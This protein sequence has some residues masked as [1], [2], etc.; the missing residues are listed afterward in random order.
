MKKLVIGVSVAL[1]L[2]FI[3]VF[4]KR[5]G[6]AQAR[7]ADKK[8]DESV[9]AVSTIV[10]TKRDLPEMV[11]ITGNVRAFNEAA[12]FPK[13]PGRVTKVNVEVG[14]IVKAGDV[15]AA[16]EGNDFA[17]RVKQ[18]EAQLMA[19]RA[20]L[21]NAQVQQKTATNGWNR[22]QALHGK[23]SMSQSDFEQS[24]AGFELS[25]VGVKAAEAQVALAEAAVGL[26]NQAYADTR[27]TSPI[28]G[29]VSKKNVEVGTQ[30]G[31][32]QPAFVVQDQSALKMQGSVSASEVALLKKGQPVKVRV[33]EL[34]GRELQGEVSSV[35]PS[36]DDVT[37]RATIEVAL[38]PTEGLLPYMFGH[39]EIAFG[40]RSGA[41]VIPANAVTNTPDGPLVYAVRDGKAV[42]LKPRVGGRFGDDVFI[43]AG[44]ADGDRIVISG[45]TGLRDGVAVQEA[46]AGKVGK[47]SG[48]G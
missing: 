18:A 10:A 35:A 39:A 26:A 44:I 1:T 23:G 7:N 29:V 30:A 48:E 36:L 6:E 28:S 38:K 32:A 27:I 47:S 43:E 34:P 25:K 15:L 5:V 20:G 16:T 11:S 31:P 22:A 8:V 37:R 24:Q 42:A 40:T 33:D 4:A 3:G 14:S 41:I 13:M 21:E 9:P 19:A 17:W 2:L 12:V 46:T 45:D